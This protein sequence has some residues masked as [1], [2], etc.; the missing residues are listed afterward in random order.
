MDF[1]L[2]YNGRQWRWA[3]GQMTR[4]KER[5]DGEAFWLS[6]FACQQEKPWVQFSENK[7]SDKAPTPFLESLPVAKLWTH[8]LEK[9]F[10][11]LWNKAQEHFSQDDLQKIVLALSDV[12]TDWTPGLNPA[13]LSLNGYFYA[14]SVE[15]EQAWGLTPELLFQ[16]DH[17][18]NELNTVALAGT[19]KRS[20]EGKASSVSEALKVEHEKVTQFYRDIQ[21]ELANGSE[22]QRQV[23][24]TFSEASLS[25]YSSI[26]HIQT[27]I[28]FKNLEELSPDFWLKKLHP[29]PALGVYPR[30][31]ANLKTLAALRQ[32]HV[33]THYGAPFGY[34]HADESFFVVMIRGHFLDECNGKKVLSRP[35]GVGVTP[36]S[37]FENEWNEISLKRQSMDKLWNKI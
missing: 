24:L 12:A 21:E 19:L 5:P 28:L 6:D 18:Q 34:S 8:S 13:D 30:T 35:L 1:A 4:Y 14:Y 23:T 9:V 27:Q 26:S 37:T 7:I 3:C 17:K 22:R 20:P 29:T 25:N 33:P 31:E 32:S 16:L 2:L 10:L 11:D 15:G 36:Y